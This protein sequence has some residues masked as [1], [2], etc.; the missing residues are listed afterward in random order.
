M[1]VFA[2]MHTLGTTPEGQER[3]F[4]LLLELLPWIREST[5]FRGVLRL[6]SPD[7]SKAITITLWADEGAML[8]SAEAA[9]GLGAL[10]AEASGSKRLALEDFE[11]VYFEGELAPKDAST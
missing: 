2:R 1:D 5:G 10:A 9:Q 11:V 8:E 7:R 6:A 4:E 3:G